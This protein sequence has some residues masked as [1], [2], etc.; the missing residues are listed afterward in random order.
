MRINYIHIL[1]IDNIRAMVQDVYLEILLYMNKNN[2]AT[3]FSV[4][5]IY[6][7]FGF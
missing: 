7:F 2:T 5:F 3:F 6:D 1:T 4:I